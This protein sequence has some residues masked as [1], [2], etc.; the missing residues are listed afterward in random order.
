MQSRFG[1]TSA[2][3]RGVFLILVASIIMG[4]IG[5]M[6]GVTIVVRSGAARS[7]LGL[8][9]NIDGLLQNSPTRTDKI[10]L[11]ES[12]AVIDAVKKVSPSVVSITITKDVQDFFGQVLTQKGGGTGF[13]ISSDGLIATNKHVVADA[14][15]TYSVFTSTGK[16]YSARVVSQ[17]P[18][19]D[20]AVVKIE[21]SGL[22]VVEFGDSDKLQ[23]GQYV[24]AIGN[25]LGEFSNTVTL[26][27]LSARNRKLDVSD[28]QGTT[29]SL[30]GLLQ[31]DAA[32]N[33]GNSGGPLINLKGQV[34]GVNTAV[35]QK[36]VAEGIGFAI[37]SNAIQT[38]VESVK[39]TG[40]IVR[41]QI[42]VRYIEITK[43]IAE[44][45]DLPI[46][47][48]AL[49]YAGTGVGELAVIPGSPADKAG[50]TEGDIITHIN[51]ERID[52]ERTLVSLIQK[53]KPGDQVEVTYLHKGEEKR[54]KVTLAA[55]E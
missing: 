8:S 37:P 28:T 23:V 6:I 31:T 32:I 9:D 1:P 54:I 47:Y 14:G 38:A 4:I 24:I 22:P 34:I 27:V 5:G 25:A 43:E 55:S 52:S 21:A 50:I 36:G 29:E 3:S 18:F 53:Y 33:P 48:G 13:I 51:R 12:S 44:K 35:A 40:K 26:G 49:V 10:V 7:S 41:P 19:N 46:D 45:A 39:R 42:G 20:L 30:T 16:E 17:D 2:R 11:E 15:A